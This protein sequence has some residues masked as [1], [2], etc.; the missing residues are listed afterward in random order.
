M[1]TMV[2]GAQGEDVRDVQSRLSTLGY[3]THPDRSG[4]FGPGTDAAVRAFQQARHLLVDGKVGPGTWQ[5]LVE[6]G[7]AIGDR[8]LY[9]RYPAARGDDVRVMQTRLNLLGFDAGREDG[10]FGQR[11]DHAVREFQRNVGLPVD[12]IVGRST[13]ETLVRLRPVGPGPGLSTVRENEA[14]LRMSDNLRGARI[15]V[16][17]GHGPAE[18]GA[19]GPGGLREADVA[20]VLASRTA[21]LLAARDA[22]PFL[23]RAGDS[24]P[25]DATRA[26]IA[27]AGGAE[28]LVSF[29]LNSHTDPLA[30]GSSVFYCGR[31]DWVSP[32]GQRL[33]ELI[34]EGLV[35]GVHL[36]DGRTHPKWFPILRETRMPAVQVEPC[37]VTNPAEEKLLREG[38]LTDRIATAVVAGIERFFGAASESRGQ[39]EAGAASGTAGAPAGRP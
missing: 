22:E 38:D 24:D 33:A 16:D 11:T 13:L 5:E 1:R 30:E 9:L 18:P 6:A 21:E 28:V 15:A 7:Y 34:Q 23:V 17:A 37:F 14:L 39:A 8:I 32:A 31:G 3:Q 20:F 19:I 25:D 35:E 12:G 4:T 26:R 36:K 29:H 2:S 10:I 27:N